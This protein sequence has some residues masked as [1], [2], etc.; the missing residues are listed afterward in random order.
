MF[1][2]LDKCV[3]KQNRVAPSGGFEITIK[4]AVF[5]MKIGIWYVC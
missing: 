1:R 5:F 2:R 3:P 4:T